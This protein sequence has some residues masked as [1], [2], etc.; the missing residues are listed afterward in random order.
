[1]FDKSVHILKEMTLVVY[2]DLLTGA[3]ISPKAMMHFPLFQIPPIFE[4]LSESLEN[5]QNFTFSR[6]ISP[7]SSDDLFLVIDHIFRISPIFPISVPFPSVL[8]KLLFPPY[9]D[10]FPPVLEKFTCFLHTLCVFRFPLL[11]P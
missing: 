3:S 4:K 11:L 6:Q 10:K 1:M 8:R 7:F 5:F 2:Q 9:F